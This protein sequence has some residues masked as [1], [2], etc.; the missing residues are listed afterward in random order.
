[1]PNNHL[2]RRPQE[3]DR[4]EFMTLVS[5]GALAGGSLLN[6][7]DALG[8]TPALSPQ[9]SVGSTHGMKYRR[10][11]RTGLMVSEIAMGCS[12]QGQKTPQ[13]EYFDKLTRIIHMALERGVNLIDTAPTYFSEKVVG[14]AIK[15]R[16]DKVYLADKAETLDRDKLIQEVE[17]SLRDLGT[18]YIDILHEHAH[19]QTPEEIFTRPG[20][21][22]ACEKLKKDGKVRFC[23]LSGHNVGIHIEAIKTGYFD[24]F[25]IPYNYL[26]RNP[27]EVLFPLAKK[28]DV[29][30]LVIKPMTGAFK[31][32]EQMAGDARLDELKLK[33]NQSNYARAS[34]KWALA[35]QQV[36]SLVIGME[37]E[38]DVIEDTAMAGAR[39]NE[40]DEKL[41]ALYAGAVS[42]DYCTMCNQCLPCPEGV[43]IPNVLR[44]M[45][46]HDNYG[47]RERARR[48]YAGL[49][50]LNNA[51]RCTDCGECEPRCPAK[52]SIVRKL[53]AA[54]TV[55]A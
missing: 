43:A 7:A 47:H 50:V 12:P 39:I 10:L 18:D 15:G 48:L 42:S 34:I 21:L 52:I 40:E 9:T 16:R 20:F 45:T 22:E 46:Y 33:F 28:L 17:Q 2:K 41:L 27:E 23:G 30:A 38:R 6:S 3:M 31:P 26:I 4:R 14:A 24:T 25:M 51:A 19:Y 5:T 29:G 53:R 44:F 13:P 37:F 54:H 32:W 49:P 8:D 36:A 11:G 55:L 35:N 1:M